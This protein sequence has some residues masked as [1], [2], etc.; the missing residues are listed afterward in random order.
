MSKIYFLLIPF[1][2]VA[3]VNAGTVTLSGTCQNY[4]VNNSI[5]FSLSNS[6]NDTAYNLII[7]PIISGAVTLNSSF[8]VNAL[9]PGRSFSIKVPL[10]N[11]GIPGTYAEGFI[12]S[13]Q[14]GLS[15]FSA[16]FPCTVWFGKPTVSPIYET[17][18]WNKDGD[19]AIINVSLFDGLGISYVGNISLMVPPTFS[20]ISNKSYSFNVEPYTYS[21]FTFKVAFPKGASSYTLA[22]VASFTS[23]DLHYT[24]LVPFVVNTSAKSV[25]PRSYYILVAGAVIVLIIIILLT[26]IIR[27]MLRKKKKPKEELKAL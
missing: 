9:A 22:A 2:L 3:L 5:M 13:Y 20:F 17:I 19:T 4:I 8:S 7:S 15:V 25:V 27:S 12:V 11:F 1:F 23:D 10:E 24:N 16:L 14:Q 18:K 21:N 26:F 6:G